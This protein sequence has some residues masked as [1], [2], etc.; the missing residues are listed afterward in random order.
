MNDNIATVQKIYAAFA[1]GDV[2]TI[3]SLMAP[4]VDWEYGQA[5]T[6]VPYLRHRVG[7]EA[8]RA[9]FEELSA[10]LQITRFVPKELLAKDGLVLAT[11]DIEGRSVRTGKVLRE[12]DE[13]HVW[14]FGPDG[15][16]VRFRHA[17]DTAQHASVYRA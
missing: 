16:V 11:I 8:V 4:D 13:V 7:A 17:L 6:E 9:F 1:Q 14:R 2:A 3:V 5:D 12:E 15:K 10:N